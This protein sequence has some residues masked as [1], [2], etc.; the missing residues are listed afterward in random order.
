MKG[1]FKGDTGS[2]D[3]SSYGKFAESSRL[4]PWAGVPRIETSETS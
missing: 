2:L 1:V 4:Y 3:Y